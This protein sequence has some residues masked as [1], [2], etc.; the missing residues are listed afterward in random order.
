MYFLF[1]DCLLPLIIWV[2]FFLSSTRV[3]AMCSLNQSLFFSAFI[4]CVSNVGEDAHSVFSLFSFCPLQCNFDTILRCLFSSWRHQ[5]STTC[6][7]IYIWHILEE[8]SAF[9]TDIQI[10]FSVA[11]RHH[12]LH[13][14]RKVICTPKGLRFLALFC[15][16]K[17]KLFFFLLEWYFHS[18]F[19]F[20]FV[21]FW[22]KV[23]IVQFVKCTFNVLC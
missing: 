18:A 17:W 19:L 23:T 2:S 15:R 13:N 5:T 11:V 16:L 8:I 4:S 1:L 14:V 21:L 9:L 22:R 7:C 6:V 20:C 12:L 3:K 10:V